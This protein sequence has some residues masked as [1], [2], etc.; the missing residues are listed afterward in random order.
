MSWRQ[1]GEAVEAHVED[2][3]VDVGR[4][5][6]LPVVS[7]ARRRQN[8]CAEQTDYPAD[9]KGNGAQGKRVLALQGCRGTERAAVDT[10]KVVGELGEFHVAAAK[11]N[12]SE[13]GEPRDDSSSAARAR[14]G[15]DAALRGGRRLHM[16][17]R[18]RRWRSGCTQRRPPEKRCPAGKTET[19]RT[20]RGR[21]SERGRRPRRT[22]SRSGVERPGGC[23]AG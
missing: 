7:K 10:G 2:Q 15:V 3:I 20:R 13:V 12:G 9:T 19:G 18:R 11:V 4:C 22:P 8:E 14:G 6:G 5:G 23:E 1:M 21:N 17:R 16:S